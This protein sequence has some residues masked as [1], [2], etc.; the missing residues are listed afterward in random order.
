MPRKK[1]KLD[2]RLRFWYDVVLRPSDSDEYHIWFGNGKE[3]FRVGEP[4]NLHDFE[5]IWSWLREAEPGI[6]EVVREITSCE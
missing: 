1:K 4:L 6:N 2:D 3:S 5:L